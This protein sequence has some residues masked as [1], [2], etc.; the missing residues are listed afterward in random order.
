[1]EDKNTISDDQYFNL[2]LPY[3]HNKV[4]NI[5]IYRSLVTICTSTIVNYRCYVKI[6][7]MLS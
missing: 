6:Q 5:D 1:M 4:S 2:L 7:L 3:P